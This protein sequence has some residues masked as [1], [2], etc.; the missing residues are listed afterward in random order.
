MPNTE[1]QMRELVETGKVDLKTPFVI[2]KLIYDE[3]ING[4]SIKNFE[5]KE[6]EDIECNEI[7]FLFGL[8]KNVHALIHRNGVIIMLITLTFHY[9]F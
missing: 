9:P 5:T 3:K 6:I 7:L 1:A 8:N 4:V 2:E